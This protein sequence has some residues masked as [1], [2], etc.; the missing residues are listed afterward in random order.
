VGVQVD[1]NRTPDL[2]PTIAVELSK[3]G[4][5][6][7][8][9]RTGR[10][11]AARGRGVPGQERRISAALT[12]AGFVAGGT[13]IDTAEA[14]DVSDPGFFQQMAGGESE[15]GVKGLSA[16]KKF[17]IEH[18]GISV[19]EP[20]KMANWYQETLGFDIKFSAEDD[21]KAVAF[22]TEWWR[23]GNARI[24]KASRCSAPGGGIE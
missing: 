21:E 19:K 6:I 3:M 17:E 9:R 2:V 23:Q 8:K 15:R 11:R 12:V 20:V 14:V 18:I 5:G 7:R 16:M 22:I 24:G 13:R 1:A 4:A 10:R